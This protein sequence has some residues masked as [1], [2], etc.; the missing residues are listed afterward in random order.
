[1]KVPLKTLADEW[2]Y[3]GEFQGQVYAVIDV[4]LHES[5]YQD[6]SWRSGVVDQ[7]ADTRSD[8]QWCVHGNMIY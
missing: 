4:L 2:S 6:S 8:T 1:M 3:L 5:S 7:I